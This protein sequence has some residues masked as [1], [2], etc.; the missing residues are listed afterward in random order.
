MTKPTTKNTE[1]DDPDWK[2]K[3]DLKPKD[4]RIK[5]ED[6]TNTKG[7]EFEDFQLSR[8]LLKVV[9]KMYKIAK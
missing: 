9:Y 6:V 2:D 5:T 1:E 4:E 3:L 8:N 7:A